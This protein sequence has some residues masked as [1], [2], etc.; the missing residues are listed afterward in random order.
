MNKKT[1]DIYK[2]ARLKSGIL[3]SLPGIR[4]LFSEIF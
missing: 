2:Q 3:T 1:S 4:E